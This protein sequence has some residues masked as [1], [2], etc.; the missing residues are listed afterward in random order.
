MEIVFPYHPQNRA[1]IYDFFLINEDSINISYFCRMKMS[2]YWGMN[3][4][5]RSLYI[6]YVLIFTLVG[7]ASAQNRQVDSLVQRG[8]SLHKLYRFAEAGHAFTQAANILGDSQED[9]IMKEMVES[10]LLLS[11]NGLSMSDYAYIPKVV[12]RRMFSREDFF[13]HYPLEDRAW[14][15]VPNQL[16]S[17]SDGLSHAVY[18]PE[19]TE[20]IYFSAKDDEG[21]RNI[22]KT[23]LQDTLWTLPVMLGES[24]TS[25][26]DEVYPL[27][28]ADGRFLYFSSKG[29]Y[30]VGGFD[31][32]VS[33]WNDEAKE[34]SEPVNMG[35]PYSS[36]YDDFLYLDAPEEGHSFFAS[37]RDCPADSMWV[38]VLEFDNVPVRH[39]VADAQELLEISRLEPESGDKA[40]AE[41][42]EELPEN[43]DR[44]MSK[45][46][47]VRSLRDSISFYTTSLEEERNQFALSN[48]DAERMRLTGVIRSRESRLPQLQDSYRKEMAELQEIEMEF[49]FSGVVFD[50]DKIMADA[51]GE[52]DDIPE[53]EYV[54]NTFGPALELQMKKPE[55]KGFDYSFMVL[56]K[57]RFAEDNTI[58]PG[59]IYQIQMFGGGGKAGVHNLRGLSPVFEFR[60]PS[61]RYTY[62]VGLFHT[63][64]D[65]LS[66]LNKVKKLGFKS[67]FI[68][69]YQDGNQISVATA[70][71]REAVVE[72][73]TKLY[74]VRIIPADGELDDA[75]T[76]GI[77][78]QAG[79]KD[80]ARVESEDGTI[81]FVVGPFAEKG[82]ADELIAFV[83]AMGVEGVSFNEIV[84]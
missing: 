19:E 57:G 11:E 38:Y 37:D 30:G 39:P 28:S 48:D 6:I 31:I 75:L 25:V 79:G 7:N 42:E 12:S 21:A 80:I 4:V 70:R 55:K 51:S 26:S 52:Q 33:E 17:I 15:K 27:L 67:A 32:Y 34:W 13:L 69:A 16:D 49:L 14:R 36:P 77:R 46:A 82:K 62:R 78:Q 72:Q 76:S 81:I 29:L 66:K 10:K 22:Y 23:S 20:T 47:Q 1:Q 18:V 40:D 74:E 2:I 3:R 41:Q 5:R 68:V 50:P 64:N 8:D 58:P 63:Y 35:F 24:L 73:V 45:M 44:Y 83:K 60:S 53:Y 9:S 84:K 43:M 61:G 59:I 71:N 65:A 54:S 56:E